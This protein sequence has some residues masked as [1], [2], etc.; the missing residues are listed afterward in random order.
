MDEKTWADAATTAPPM[1]DVAGFSH[2][3]IDTPGLRTHVATIGA[4]EP[5]LMLHGFPQH[6]WQ[7]RTVGVGLADTYRV[8]CPDLR[9]SGWTRAATSRIERFSMRDDLLALM[10]AM[11]LDRVRIVAHDMGA[12]PAAHIAYAHPDRVHAMVVLS[13]PPPFMPMTLG[14][15]PAM[16]H[17]P[18]LRFHRRGQSLAYL[19]EAPY[20]AKPMP[21][22]TV[23]TYLGP[24]SD[25]AIE[26]AIREIY[27]GLIGG[28]VPALATGRYRKERL[29]VP[30]LYAFSE[31]DEPLT[32]SFVRSHSGDTSRYAD[33]FEI[34]SV[35][36]AAHFMTDD[37]PE[38]VL[39]LARDFFA[40]VG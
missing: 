13:V 1:P 20:V 29:R 35:D 14:M 28:E 37:N 22:L 30:S 5:V 4:G 2:E 3:F 33:H 31:K 6:W 34:A 38:E 16:K 9:G 17:V 27:R 15:L 26:D 32:A 39:S 7:W 8:I 11:E 12:L 10:D 25:P 24:L 40:R 36:G 19:F 21:A 18:K 23:A